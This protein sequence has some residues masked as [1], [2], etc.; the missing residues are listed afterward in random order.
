MAERRAYN[1]RTSSLGTVIGITLTLFMLGLLGFLLINARQLEQHFKENVKVDIFLKREVKEVEVMRFSKQLDVEP[2][3]HRTLYVTADSAAA[4]LKEDLG[5]DFLGVLGENTLKPSI[6]LNVKEGYAHPDSLKWIAKQ[7]QD[8]PHVDEVSYNP[9]L[10]E[11]INDNLGKIRWVLVGFSALLLFIAVALINNTIRLAIYSK[12]FLIRTM[13]LVG[14]TSWFIKKPFLGKSV[15]QGMISAVV[16]M[17]LLVGMIQ[18]LIHFQ[19]DLE[20]LVKPIPLAILLGGVV[21]AGLLLS[22]VSTWF[23]VRRYLRMDTDELNWS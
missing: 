5:E 23:A 16:A 9:M 14:A 22:L 8:D 7:L 2:Y 4:R 11:N 1:V 20:L 19:P 12:R 13:H 21:I 3:T 17:G 10:V 15:W 6:E 18:L